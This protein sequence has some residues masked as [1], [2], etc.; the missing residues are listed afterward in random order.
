LIPC[1]LSGNDS[2]GGRWAQQCHCAR[3]SVRAN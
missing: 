2:R 1:L 3:T